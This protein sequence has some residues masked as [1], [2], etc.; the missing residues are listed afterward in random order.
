MLCCC[1]GSNFRDFGVSGLV[2]ALCALFLFV[3]T[4]GA[5]GAWSP[6][7]GAARC[8][9]YFCNACIGLKNHIPQLYGR[10]SVSAVGAS[11]TVFRIASVSLSER[12]NKQTGKSDL[13]L[14]KYR[15]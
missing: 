3:A 12:K 13:V 9:R 4:V 15:V 6:S 7:V 11:G 5:I 14:R 1:K 2:L 10:E 8:R